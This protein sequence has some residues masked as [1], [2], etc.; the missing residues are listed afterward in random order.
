[1]DYQAITY[2]AGQSFL[3]PNTVHTSISKIRPD[4]RKTNL[5]PSM[6]ILIV[7]GDT[8]NAASLLRVWGNLIFWGTPQNNSVVGRA[9]T[10]SLVD[11]AV[12]IR[13]MAERQS[14]SR[15]RKAR[16][17]II[18]SLPECKERSRSTNDIILCTDMTVKC[19]ISC[20][21]NR[22]QSTWRC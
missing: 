5:E 18:A 11:N 19:L 12:G 3:I 22:D 21:V 14:P 17:S 2:C 9:K 15:S 16:T 20:K 1:M 7:P 8:K 10:V 6:V 13:G 4:Y